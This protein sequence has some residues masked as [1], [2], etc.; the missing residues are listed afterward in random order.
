MLFLNNNDI[1]YPRG[2]ENFFEEMT[3]LHGPILVLRGYDHLPVG[4]R[5]DIDI[6]VEPNR[7]HDFVRSIKTLKTVR[8]RFD[9]NV[10]RLGLI[11]GI[12][13]INDYAVPLDIMFQIAYSGLPYQDAHELLANSIIH[14]SRK[15]KVPAASD[16][17]RISILKELL[18]N[19]RARKDKLRYLT[20]ALSEPSC[21]PTSDVFDNESL[22]AY[23][24]NLVC[25]KFEMFEL[26]FLVRRKLFRKHFMKT[27]VSAIC[28]MIMFVYIKYILETRMLSSELVR[29]YMR[30]FL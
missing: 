21:D 24:E 5:N 26:G 13:Y 2:L 29:L 6:F 3:D 23:R 10:C 18:H 4:Y 28:S 27:P 8:A 12:V 16:E 7:V 22:R 25:R 1:H 17:I 30:K 11:K 19:R 20:E 15:F 9:I 14:H